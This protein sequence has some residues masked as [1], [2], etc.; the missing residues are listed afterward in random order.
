M[1]PNV[2]T[3]FINCG[4][5]SLHYTLTMETYPSTGTVEPK[6]ERAVRVVGLRQIQG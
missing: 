2:V 6:P 1:T 4:R 5:Y 3:V